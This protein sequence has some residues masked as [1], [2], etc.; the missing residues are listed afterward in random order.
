MKELPKTPKQIELLPLSPQT[1]KAIFE[2][3]A[4]IY[5]K[6]YGGIELERLLAN[7]I[8]QKLLTKSSQITRRFIKG[9]I[10]AFHLLRLNP[11][12]RWEELLK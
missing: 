5:A 2:Q 1:L 7:G 12:K 4:H 9:T 6:A 11:R 8:Y 3:L 10:E